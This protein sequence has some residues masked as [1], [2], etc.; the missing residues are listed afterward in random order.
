MKAC[1]FTLLNN[2]SRWQ[3]NTHMYDTSIILRSS[4]N[5]FLNL[6]RCIW[7]H[8]QDKF[9]LSTWILCINGFKFLEKKRTRECY[10]TFDCFQAGSFPAALT[11]RIHSFL[12]DFLERGHFNL[13]WQITNKWHWKFHTQMK[14]DA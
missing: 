6:L 12:K 7:H 5:C 8:V 14:G 3:I 9:S 11:V 2:T 13:H 1:L 10:Q 4:I